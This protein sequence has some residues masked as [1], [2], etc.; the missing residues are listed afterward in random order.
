MSYKGEA[1]LPN[2]INN[3]LNY[4]T[5]QIPSTDYNEKDVE[6]Y[7]IL[8]HKKIKNH[9]EKYLD[10]LGYLLHL[11]IDKQKSMP[12]RYILDIGFSPNSQFYPHS[13]YLLVAVYKGNYEITELL[14]QNGANVN[15]TDHQG[16]TPL[17]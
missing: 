1:M 7:F 8:L 12:V 9:A 5:L 6:K 10:T 11:A 13:S 4:L 2:S 15:A 14:L 3:A 17:D 16:F